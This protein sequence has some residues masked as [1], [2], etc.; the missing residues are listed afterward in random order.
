[1]DIKIPARR[2]LSS[3][4]C[5]CNKLLHELHNF[6]KPSMIKLMQLVNAYYISELHKLAAFFKRLFILYKD[7]YF[8][9][10]NSD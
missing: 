1:M 6:K 7:T 10:L 8:N 5:N 4:G 3:V 9:K 2:N